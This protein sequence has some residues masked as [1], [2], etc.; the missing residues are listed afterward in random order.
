M[1]VLC[2][3]TEAQGDL[4]LCFETMLIHKMP[5]LTDVFKHYCMH[6][7]MSSD[8]SSDECHLFLRKCRDKSYNSVLSLSTLYGLSGKLRKESDYEGVH[9][10]CL[11]KST[12]NCVNSSCSPYLAMEC[13]K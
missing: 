6:S 12:E 13:T 11:P 2:T 4:M 1:E 9:K 7:T 3:V 5:F 10:I 8:S